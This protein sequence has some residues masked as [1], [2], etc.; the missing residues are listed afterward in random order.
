MAIAMTLW[1]WVIGIVLLTQ[2]RGL[3]LSQAA[4]VAAVAALGGLITWAIYH[5]IS[6]QDDGMGLFI[7][8]LCAL[9][10]ADA[11]TVEAAVALQIAI[12]VGT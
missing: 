2:S 6:R 7:F 1:S 10:M 5:A 9:I 4:A 3:P 11:Q 12:G 8:A